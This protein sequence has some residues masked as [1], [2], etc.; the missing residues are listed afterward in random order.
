MTGRGGSGGAPSIEV[1]LLQICRNLL[2]RP[3]LRRGP[4]SIS[5]ADLRRA[6]RNLKKA[7]RDGAGE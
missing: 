6:I 4:F 7:P 5:D 1:E 2:K 3:K